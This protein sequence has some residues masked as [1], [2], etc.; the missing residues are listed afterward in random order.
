[1]LRSNLTQTHLIATCTTC[2]APQPI[3]LRG[4]GATAPCAHCGAA[5]P[6]APEVRQRIDGLRA[7]LGARDDKPRQLTA[8][9]LTAAD[10]LHGA[11]LITIVICWALFGGLAVYVSLDHDVG[12]VRFLT[13]GEPSEQWWLLWAFAFGLPLSFALLEGA[14]GWI[15]GVTAGALPAPP[16]AQGR[17]PRCRCCA[18]ELP[19]GTALRRCTYCDTDN[20]VVGHRYM[21]AEQQLDD[22]LDDLERAFDADLKARIDRGDSIAMFGGVAPFFLLFI[23]PAVG[24]ANPGQPVLWVA[25]AA[26]V[27]IAGVL[28]L[29]ARWRRLPVNPLELL[30]LGQKVYIREPVSGGRSV[31]AQLMLPEGPVSLLDST[32]E[33]AQY[34]VATHRRGDDL[35]V[36]VYRVKPGKRPL[37]DQDRAR[38]TTVELREHNRG[39]PRIRRLGL[40]REG[41]AWHTYDGN[42]ATPHLSGHPS[43]KPPYIVV[44]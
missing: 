7:K 41:P 43:G 10:A 4:P 30:T 35:E 31:G 36:I 38:L 28:T 40:L 37:S 44:N 25:P 39:T 24:L 5:N 13:E 15:H 11:G 16:V 32:P 23:G 17:E 29:W 27:V 42:E 2:G 14:V 1:M 3:A 18:A 12:L 6:L 34:A 21:K 8:K 20:L 9:A 22:A 33:D 19:A 26:M